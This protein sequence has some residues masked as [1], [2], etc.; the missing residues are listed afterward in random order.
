VTKTFWKMA[1][2][3]ALRVLNTRRRRGLP[4]SS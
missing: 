3:Q 2:E 1:I 4:L